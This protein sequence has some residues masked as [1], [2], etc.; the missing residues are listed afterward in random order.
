M[1][2]EIKNINLSSVIFSVYP[3]MIFTINAVSSFLSVFALGEDF[4]AMEKLM[5]GVLWAL[6]D[7]MVFLIISLAAVFVY[8][9]FCSFGVR[10]VRFEVAG[11]DEEQAE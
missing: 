2:L 4:T 10:G 5:Q 1:K 11:T 8:N 9:L 3:L 6:G 7:T